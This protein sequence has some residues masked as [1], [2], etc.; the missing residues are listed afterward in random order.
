MAKIT[1]R[2]LTQVQAFDN[3][4]QTELKHGADNVAQATSQRYQAAVRSWRNKPL[5]TRTAEDRPQRIRRIISLAG[6]PKPR[7]IFRW[8]DKGTKAHVIAPKRSPVLV[9]NLGYSARTQPVARANVGTG[10]ATGRKVITAKPVN[11]PGTKARKFS[12]TYTTEAGQQ[13]EI[14]VRAAIARARKGR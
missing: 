4:L 14:E 12:Q 5:F 9:F 7:Q 3:R 1:G 2:V 8:V 13:L 6:A 11:H 10:I